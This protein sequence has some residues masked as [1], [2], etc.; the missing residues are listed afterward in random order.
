V[1]IFDKTTM[2]VTTGAATLALGLTLLAPAQQANATG[3]WRIQSPTTGKCVQWNGYGKN[4]T[5]VKCAKKYAQYWG[6]EGTQLVNISNEYAGW[7]LDVPKKAERAPVGR[8]CAH[9]NAIMAND[10]R[11]GHKTYMAGDGKYLKTVNGKIVCG[12]RT[13]DKKKMQWKLIA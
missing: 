5:L 7:C 6:F 4:I 1:K 9:A 8:A 2:A 10:K 3:I 13:A 12:K 11:V